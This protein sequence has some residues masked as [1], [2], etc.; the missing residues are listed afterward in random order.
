MPISRSKQ[1]IPRLL[2]LGGT[3]E[4]VALAEALHAQG[5]IDVITSLAG[6]TRDPRLPPGALRVGGF[7]GVSGLIDYLAQEKIDLL[8]D[9]THPFAAQMS[10]HAVTAAQAR[11]VPLLRLMR[12]AWGQEPGDAW[13]AV[14]DMRQAAEHCR[15]KRVLLAIGQKDLAAF[16]RVVGAFFVAR[17]IEKPKET[18]PFGDLE[19]ILSRGPFVLED[20][21]RLIEEKRIELIVAKNSGGDAGY[22]KIA[23]AR[24]ARIPVVMVERPKAPGSGEIVPDVAAALA[25]IAA[26]LQKRGSDRAFDP[27]TTASDKP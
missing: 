5:N 25:W 6:R 10:A 9:A 26:W 13:I 16:A 21:L 15:G 3:G 24:A 14:A 11:A 19:I 17:M 7:G 22:A 18:P 20:E 8:I 27:A 2:I 1:R 12:P 4:S 23:A